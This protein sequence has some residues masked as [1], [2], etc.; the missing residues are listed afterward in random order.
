MTYQGAET[1][2][3]VVLTSLPPTTIGTLTVPLLLTFWT[4]ESRPSRWD[5]PLA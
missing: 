2:S 5:E 1:G 4:V 3:E